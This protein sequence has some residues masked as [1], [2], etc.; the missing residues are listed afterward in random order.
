MNI[1]WL[2]GRDGEKRIKVVCEL[3]KIEKVKKMKI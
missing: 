1:Y 2:V 3:L